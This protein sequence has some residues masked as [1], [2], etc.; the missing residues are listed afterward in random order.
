MPLSLSLIP[1]M[2]F[3]GM[4]DCCWLP[5]HVWGVLLSEA[6]E[7]PSVYTRQR[8]EIHR[9]SQFPNLP[10]LITQAKF[11]F[12]LL[13]C[14]MHN[15]FRQQAVKLFYNPSQISLP[16]LGCV[17]GGCVWGV[18]VWGGYCER[19]CPSPA[20]FH[21]TQFY[22]DSSSHLHPFI[23]IMPD[24]FYY[25]FAIFIFRPRLPSTPEQLKGVVEWGCEC[26]AS[27]KITLGWDFYPKRYIVIHYWTLV[28]VWSNVRVVRCLA[29]GTKA[30]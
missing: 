18:C 22:L 26:Q 11:Q 30:Q 12:H 28:T 19:W 27:P 3:F 14:I 21:L 16:L 8:V 2:I 13:I 23:C 1:A 24:F 10:G 4:C 6:W 5:T 7:L 20:S 25:F 9:D 15:F 17:W 29:K